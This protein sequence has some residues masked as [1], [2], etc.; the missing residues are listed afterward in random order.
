MLLRLPSAL[1]LVVAALVG[2]ACGEKGPARPTREVVLPLLQQ[3]AASIK[4][5]GE[6]VNPALGVKST[7]NIEAVDVQEQPE[8]KDQPWHGTIRFKIETK[9]RDADGTETND[10]LDKR[11]N[12]AYDLATGKWRMR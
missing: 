11:F 12:Y 3:E 2:V 9:M 7:W 5:D 1:V 10:R 8:N 4:A 6:K